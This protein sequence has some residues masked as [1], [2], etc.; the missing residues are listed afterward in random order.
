M[1]LNDIKTKWKKVKREL[2]LHRQDNCHHEWKHIGMFP[3][4]YENGK[5]TE[6]V[7]ISVCEKC[8]KVD[9]SITIGW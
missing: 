5:V 4:K 9:K 1:C 8:A 3:Q 6:T 2:R 7:E